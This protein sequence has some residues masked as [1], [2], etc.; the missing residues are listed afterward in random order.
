MYVA[1]SF[2]PKWHIL[3]DIVDTVDAAVT[4]PMGGILLPLVV[5][6]FKT[7]SAGLIQF[8]KH[9]KGGNYSKVF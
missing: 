4:C 6:M 7:S 1:T 2:V 8:Y 3:C 5:I 9:F